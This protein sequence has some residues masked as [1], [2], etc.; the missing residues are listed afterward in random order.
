MTDYKND[1]KPEVQ[2]SSG[3]RRIHLLNEKQTKL[4]SNLETDKLI[5]QYS[6][7]SNKFR[8]HIKPKDPNT[9]AYYGKAEQ[10]Y[11]DSIY[12]IVNYYPFDGTL[13]EVYSWH[14]DSSHLDSS[15][16]KSCWPSSVGHINLN[17]SEYIQFYAGP[18]AIEQITKAG[19]YNDGETGLK[20]DAAKGNTV[21]FWLKK[22]SFNTGQ[23]AYEVIFDIGPH[24]AHTDA[25][26]SANFTVGLKGAEAKPLRLTYKS[27]LNGVEDMALGSAALNAAAI[28]D[29]KW[30]HYALKVWQEGTTLYAKLYIDGQV[31]S[32]NTANV[33][34]P[35]A[36]ADRFMGGTIG[37]IQNAGTGT[38]SASIDNFRFWKGLRNS[39]EITR[40]YDKSVYAS[41]LSN[42]NYTSR[43]GLQYTFNKANVGKSDRDSA[44]ID[45]SGNIISGKIYNYRNSSRVN[46]S[47][48]DL[49]DATKNTEQKDPILI[50]DHADVLALA[51]ELKTIGIAYDKKNVSLLSNNIPDFFNEKEF[52]GEDNQEFQKLLHLL[53]SQ[54]DEIKT[55]LDSIRRVST[56][57]Y[58]ESLYDIHSDQVDGSQS[59]RAVDRYQTELSKVDSSFSLENRIDFYKKKLTNFGL[60]PGDFELLWT[61]RVEEIVESIVDDKRLERGIQETRNLMYGALANAANYINKKKGTESSYDAILNSLGLGREVVSFNVYDQNAEIY[62]PGSTTKQEPRVV[63]TNSVSFLDNNT[64]TI[65]MT[66]SSDDASSFIKSDSSEVEY[67]FEGNFVF[68]SKKINKQTH[69]LLES[70]VFGI[71]QVSSTENNL[72]TTIPNNASLIIKVVK[73]DINSNDAKFVLFSD[74]NIIADLETE[75]FRDVY[76]N[77]NWNLAIRISK[78]NDNKFLQTSSPKY[79]VEFIGNNYILDDLESSFHKTVSITETQ[80]NNFRN[81]NK[82]IFIGAHNTNI[83]GANKTK[84][85]VKFVNLSAWK[86]SLSNEEIQN[87]AKTIK[88]FGSNRPHKYV[89]LHSDKNTHFH[90]TALLRIG[91]EGVSALDENNKLL[92]SDQT[93]G[94]ALLKQLKGVSAGTKYPFTSSQFSQNLDSVIQAEYFSAV[95]NIPITNSDSL[96]GIQTKKYDTDRFDKTPNPEIKVLSFEKSMNRIVSREMISFLSGIS[97]YNN[98]L[99]EPVN[100]YRKNYKLLENLRTKFFLNIK[101]D[102]QL[103]RF[104]SYYRWIDKAIGQFLEK[105]VPASVYANTGIENVVES[106]SLERNKIDHKLINIV[107]R[108]VDLSTNL[109]SINE[110]L[111]DWA[112]GHA[113]LSGD[114]N[115]NCRWQ[116]DRKELPSNRSKIQKVA[117]TV[118]E[119]PANAQNFREYALRNLT[120]PYHHTMQKQNIFQDG[121]NRHENN[122]ADYYKIVNQGKEILIK[123]STVEKS[124][125]CNDKIIPNEKIKYI[126]K[127]ETD[128]DGGYGD[129]KISLFAPFTMYSTSVDQTY[130][131]FNHNILLNGVLDDGPHASEM[132]HRNVKV[133]T[134]GDERPEAYDLEIEPTYIKIKKTTKQQSFLRR[135]LS[136]TKYYSTRN[137]KT[138]LDKLILGNYKNE[139]EIVQTNSKLINNSYL[140]DTEGA[141]LAEDPSVSIYVNDTIDFKKPIRPRRSHVI[142]N[143]FNTP[144]STETNQL[145]SRDLESEEYS[146]YNTLNLR[147]SNVRNILDRLSVEHSVKGGFRPVLGLDGNQQASIHKT[148]RNPKRSKSTSELV[149]YDNS[150][151]VN[152]TPQNDFSYSWITASIAESE[153]VHNFLA[154]NAN[155]GHQHNFEVSGSLKSY[156]TINFLTESTGVSFLPLN[157]Y[158]ARSISTAN[159]QLSESGNNLNSLILSRQGPYGWPTWKQLKAEQNPIVKAL[160][161]ENKYSVSFRSTESSPS[162]YPGINF[163][164]QNTEEDTSIKEHSRIPTNYKEIM[165]T[166]RFRPLFYSMHSQEI[167]DLIDL[168]SEGTRELSTG[169][170]QEDMKSMWYY[171]SFLSSVYGSSEVGDR[172]IDVNYS[173]ENLL[174]QSVSIKT[175]VQNDISTYANQ[176]I[177]NQLPILEVPYQRNQNLQNL[178]YFIRNV[179]EVNPFPTLLKELNYIEKIYPKETNTYTKNARTRERFSFFGWTDTRSARNLILSGNI[180]YGNFLIDN[181]NLKMFP[182]ITSVTAEEEFKKSFYNTTDIVDLNN[183]TAATSIASC[184]YVTSSKWVLD[185]R[186]NFSARPTSIT[187]SYF[188]SGPAFMANRDQATRGSGILQND[189]SI[190]ALGINN[191]HGAPPFAAL[192]NRRIPQKFGSDVYLAGESKWEAADAHPVGPFYESYEKY[193]EEV[194]LVGQDYSLVPEF[195]ITKYAE[196]ILKDSVVDNVTSFMDDF[197][198]VTGALINQSSGDIDI[199]GTF[200]KTYSTSDFLKYFEPL[201]ENIEDNNFNLSPGRITLRCRAVKRFLPYRGFYPAER[202]VQIS[203]IFNRSYLPEDS[204]DRDF[205]GQ[206]AAE[207]D[208]KAKKYL[209]LRI[210]NSK[211][212][213]LKPLMAPGVLMNSIKAG[214]A[215]DYPLFTSNVSNALKNIYEA[216]D[217]GDFNSIQNHSVIGSDTGLCF[218]GSAI[219]STED[220]G[221]P[222]ISGSVSRRVT[223]E[224]LLNPRSLFNEVIHDNEPHPSGTLLYG[225]I[226]HFAALERPVLFGNLNRQDTIRYTS[227]L[228]DIDAAAF[229][230][231]MKPYKSAIN[232]FTAETVNFF[233]E[234]GRLQTLLSEAINPELE[235]GK[236]YKMRVYLQ[237]NK[238]VMYDRHSAFG[239]PVD[240]GNP[241]M[242]SYTESTFGGS[243]ESTANLSLTLASPSS[244]DLSYITTASSLPTLSITDEASTTYNYK[245]YDSSS[246]VSVSDTTTTKHINV[247]SISNAPDF[248]TSFASLA[249]SLSIQGN[250]TATSGGTVTL[251]STTPGAAGNSNISVATTNP[252]VTGT[253]YIADAG[254]S[255]TPSILSNN[256]LSWTT[257]TGNAAALAIAI[258]APA[259]S[260]A[261]GSESAFANNPANYPFLRVTDESSTVHTLRFYDS[262]SITM[263]TIDTAA[264]TTYINLYNTGASAYRSTTQLISAMKT[265]LEGALAVAVSESPSGSMKITLNAVGVPSNAGLASGNCFLDNNTSPCSSGSNISTVSSLPSFSGGV[266]TAITSE[267]TFQAASDALAKLKVYGN[268]SSAEGGY[269]P[270]IRLQD[271]DGTTHTFYFYNQSVHGSLSNTTSATYISLSTTNTTN[272]TN[273]KSA[274]DAVSALNISTAINSN[275]VTL[276]DTTTGTTPVIT[277]L[278]PAGERVT[279]VLSGIITNSSLSWT[280]GTAA[281]STHAILNPSSATSADSH[282]FLPYVPPFLDPGTTPYAEISYTATRDGEHNIPQ[283][284]EGSTITYYNM[285]QPNN[286]LVNTNYKE[287][288]NLLA[289]LDL[290]SYVSLVSDNNNFNNNGE[291][292]VQAPNP[293]PTKYRWVIQTKWETPVLDFTKSEVSSLN[294]QTNNVKKVTDS[295]WKTRYQDNYYEK[296]LKST[297]NYLTASTGMWHQEGE[298]IPHTGPRGY[299]LG[300]SGPKEAGIER[301]LAAIL[302][303]DNQ[304]RHLITDPNQNPEIIKK[305]GKV[306]KN[307][308]IYEAVVAIPYFN[309]ENEEKIN[310]FPLGD[311]SYQD[312]VELNQSRK[313]S[314]LNQIRAN[315]DELFIQIE[316]EKYEKWKNL[317]GINAR[318]NIAYQIRMMNKFIIPPHFDFIRNSNVQKHVQ[319]IFQFKANL[320]ER[321]L[322][323]MWQNL[324]PSSGQG[325]SISQH[326]Q[327]GR[328]PEEQPE[329]KYDVEYISNFL[330]V[331]SSSLFNNKS[332]N[333][334]NPDVF[335]NEKVKWLVFKAKF[336]GISDYEQLKK[337][338]IVPFVEDIESYSGTIPDLQDP[339]IIRMREQEEASTVPET[340]MDNKY[341]YNWPYDFFSIVELAEVQSKVDFYEEQQDAENISAGLSIDNQISEPEFS[342]E[343]FEEQSSA[344]DSSAPA[345]A[346]SNLKEEI[347][348]SFV[349]RNTLKAAETSLSSQPRVY[350]ISEGS[351]KTGSE[352]I[353]LNG[354]LQQSGAENDY[355]ISGNTITFNFTP[356]S[357]DSILVSYIKE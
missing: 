173:S 208:E 279:S 31:E 7:F 14:H 53:A 249:N 235:S 333:Y 132:P 72:T 200:F 276:T 277:E 283:I 177:V 335:I 50:S 145:A 102:N 10:Y 320:N 272:A 339:A 304:Q 248:A 294:L 251:T 100:K 15:M 289:S 55:N 26:T 110:L 133:F 211:A 140:V 331:S 246:G 142:K 189:Y 139:Y 144:G 78:N 224:D 290:K 80:Y 73:S 270:G 33:P 28:A 244:F 258:N 234:Q 297:T 264:N 48:I 265:A 273:F 227:N 215:V 84:T 347:V 346:S 118:S 219:N 182:D 222:R 82:T 242:I 268:A 183:T 9:F 129:G 240:D 236:I 23:V 199:G 95:E 233:L 20:I 306:A 223:F 98:L 312:A 168:N 113:P 269:G 99:G 66:K 69:I 41:D 146:V 261:L 186:Q 93:S 305:I 323:D 1:K 61:A 319:Y 355:T 170:P 281:T 17:Y 176:D 195:T 25:N 259:N 39:R 147:N 295:P 104:I 79:I 192:Y 296:S 36:A 160:R 94:S 328:L 282:G 141:W 332:S 255:N 109:L 123:S 59:S 321:D 196:K 336:R 101:N 45:T 349:T 77:T 30:H 81:S 325:I 345:G 338:S 157:I 169:I 285:D 12:N 117:T 154:R 250:F 90:D 4:S 3:A 190:F 278:A 62:L 47:A 86:C 46:T 302:G 128:L 32:L 16:I 205:A 5:Q 35:I 226:H 71:Q 213:A 114:E 197:L 68:P 239:P 57:E 292:I 228:F 75:Y 24:P 204:Y 300:V 225:N 221:I 179:H 284:I 19:E 88:Y 112:T 271:G 257:V 37:G 108:D 70:S 124:K 161:K 125:K 274:V 143:I 353:Y 51:E 159:N 238:T 337:K 241:S 301:N 43:L 121:F 307:K 126:A 181:N 263:Q 172:L 324:Y 119:A 231:A 334:K 64:S 201:R 40:F 357:D 167:A 209:K 229:N 220:S 214:V 122:I 310:L 210:N 256:S 202:V 317:P 96:S 308:E 352:S 185:S 138:N 54:F 340:E 298:L 254:G 287:A 216:T 60:Q 291:D 87:S 343:Q 293:G 188:N 311:Q 18:L 309:S 58:S 134:P 67:T 106:H 49:S 315:N 252:T 63:E 174:G 193:A 318:E 175:T 275:V 262:T 155:I 65:H 253:A 180:S 156:E 162:S 260:K 149:S 44:V 165:V 327:V 344:P 191:L 56:L 97:S 76:T 103:E 354:V 164:Y 313:N 148:Y 218:T 131:N 316:K 329:I 115:E 130:E 137:I 350:T 203:E 22:D 212:Q 127:A 158:T 163:D 92:I 42:T 351:V 207:N 247:N 299:V 166:S 267:L 27:G 2:R 341:G 151:I 91:L 217:A 322:A 237:N 314:F 150:F 326:S 206:G 303:F 245:F 230:S 184:S 6:T 187:A 342:Y 21:E 266:N 52:K 280:P 107:T 348:N 29:S 120:R 89:D 116:K 288:M 8:P 105:A 74:S 232:N 135:D 153:N 171:D 152:H 136:T 194:R 178:N 198:E 83:V 38:L 243:G 286:H 330:D 111:Y 11:E 34:N 85:D 356:N 13:E